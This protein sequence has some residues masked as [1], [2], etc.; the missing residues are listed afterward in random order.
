MLKKL[1]MLGHFIFASCCM[2]MGISINDIDQEWYVKHYNNLQFVESAT[3]KL[4]SISEFKDFLVNSKRIATDFELNDY[5]G[6][7]L[8][9]RHFHLNP[10]EVMVELFERY[11]DIDSLVTS[12]FSASVAMQKEAAP[13]SWIFSGSEIIPFEFSTDRAVKEGL[14]RIQENPEVFLQL[15]DLIIRNNLQELI[16]LSIVKR[17]NL[18]CDVNES[19]LEKSYGNEARDM[20]YSV[21]QKTSKADISSLDYVTAWH[22]NF[23]NDD[24]C[25]PDGHCQNCRRQEDHCFYSYHTREK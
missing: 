24:T 17:A 25:V 12:A 8:I 21:V 7:R 23:Q 18:A 14:T 9:H 3:E 4:G 15:K 1:F 11:D 16:A 20:G 2:S 10:G 13:A 22:L 5:L 19:R 6:F